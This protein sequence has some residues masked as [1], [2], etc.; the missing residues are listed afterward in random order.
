MYNLHGV[1]SMRFIDTFYSGTLYG[2]H[3]VIITIKW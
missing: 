2:V 1:Q 3:G